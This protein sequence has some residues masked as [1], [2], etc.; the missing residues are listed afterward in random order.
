MDRQW[1]YPRWNGVVGQVLYGEA[2]IGITN[3]D[4]THQRHTA[5]DYSAPA[6]TNEGIILSKGPSPASPVLNIINVFN[7]TC[8]LWILVTISVAMVVTVILDSVIHLLDPSTPRATVATLALELWGDMIDQT[9]NLPTNSMAKSKVVF[10][11]TFTLFGM[12]VIGFFMK[13]TGWFG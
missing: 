4:I 6:G 7:L 10:L 1:V 9:K 11:F 5:V 12:F 2:D 13:V 8:W 3:I